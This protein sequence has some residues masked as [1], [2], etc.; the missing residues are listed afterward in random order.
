MRKIIFILI[1]V[2]VFF[3]GEFL[4]VNTLSPWIR[5]QLLLLLIIFIDFSAGIRYALLTALCA[6]LLKDSLGVGPFG[7][8]MFCLVLCTYATTFL[9]KYLY[10]SGFMFPRFV[11]VASILGIYF[12]CQYLLRSIFVPVSFVEAFK[13]IFVPETV[14]TLVVMN[15]VFFHLKKC[16]LKSFAI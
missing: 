4:F 13:T 6:G 14:A 7:I 10:V 11:L 3:L 8:H 9:R 16:A 15:L 5:P 12:I 1:A 2:F